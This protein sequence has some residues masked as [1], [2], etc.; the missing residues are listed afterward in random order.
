MSDYLLYHNHHDRCRE[1]AL[2]AK[3]WFS[4]LRDRTPQEEELLMELNKFLEIGHDKK[5]IC[6]ELGP[7]QQY[8]SSE[9][10]SA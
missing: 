8:R 4:M 10:S 9:K 5:T 1:V 6:R 3:D 2:A 7:D